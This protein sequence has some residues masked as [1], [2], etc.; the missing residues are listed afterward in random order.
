[1]IAYP[2]KPKSSSFSSEYYERKWNETKDSID[3]AMSELETLREDLGTDLYKAI[4]KN[5]SKVI[6]VINQRKLLRDVGRL[7][8]TAEC[9]TPKYIDVIE[10]I[11]K[12]LPERLQTHKNQVLLRIKNSIHDVLRSCD[13]WN[14]EVTRDDLRPYTI[15]ATCNV[16]SGWRSNRTEYT[17]NVPF[18]W[19][20]TPA[21]KVM[22]AFDNKFFAIECRREI[23]MDQGD[24][25][26][27]WVNRAVRTRKVGFKEPEIGYAAIN[28]N[29]FCG[30]GAT[31]ELAIHAMKRDVA[32]AAKA[33]ML[34]TLKASSAS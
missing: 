10:R 2:P 32:K 16:R 23:A 12:K 3:D 33:R 18:N 9:K 15:T 7:S 27:Y 1:M 29:E 28:D 14:A 34:A 4:L 17:A 22:K 20:H 31:P 26:L 25:A 30:W 24:I 6:A 21:A 13:Y 5:R 8:K 19:I 11:N